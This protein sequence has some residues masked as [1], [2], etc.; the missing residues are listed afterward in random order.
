M[1][2]SPSRPAV[3]SADVCGPRTVRH[4]PAAGAW[5]SAAAWRAARRGV[6]PGSG[7]R[8]VVASND[9]D[10]EAPRRARALRV[11]DPGLQRVRQQCR[12][13]TGGHHPRIKVVRERN[14]HGE[15][16]D[17]RGGF[18]STAR[19]AGSASEIDR[20]SQLRVG[21]NYEDFF[22]NAQLL[23]RLIRPF[24][25]SRVAPPAGVVKPG[26]ARRRQTWTTDHGR[27]NP[28]EPGYWRIVVGSGHIAR[29]QRDCDRRPR[30]HLQAGRSRTRGNTGSSVRRA[31]TP[32]Q[33][34]ML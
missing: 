11:D 34:P 21:A 18:R 28:T 32:C 19:P 25:R 27:W 8:P 17:L 33:T 3:V 20:R 5:D 12:A 24:V 7:V 30:S 31:R 16:L 15:R 23:R 4:H 6:V 10:D 22:H 13:P 1:R 2:R 14:T 26:G 29:G 9:L